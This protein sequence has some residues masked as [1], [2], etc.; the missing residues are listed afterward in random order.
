MRRPSSSGGSSVNS[1]RPATP[2]VRT[3]HTAPKLPRS[4]TPTSRSTLP[5]PKSVVGQPRSSTPVQSSTP[6]SRSS[7]PPASKL[8]S[9]S[10]TPTRRPS[11]PSGLQATVAPPSH[12]SY[13]TKSGSATSSNT[14]SIPAVSSVTRSGPRTNSIA[15]SGPTNSIQRSIPP[16]NSVL[17]SCPTVSKIAAPSRGTSPAIRSRPWKP[18]EMPGYSHDTP[19]NL[20]TTLPER[21]SPARGRPGAPS[22]TRSSSI[23]NVPSARPRRQSCSPSRGT[24]PK[25]NVVSGSSVPAS[26]RSGVNRG[27]SDSPVVIGTKM[28]ERV[29]NSRR[30]APPKHDNL[31]SSN[32]CSVKSSLSPD[33]IGFGRTLSKKSLDM[34]MRHMDIRRSIP[35]TLRPLM[36]NI[37]ASSFYSVKSGFMRGR[38]VSA[39]GSSLATSSNASSEQSVSNSAFCLEGNEIEHDQYSEKGGR[40]L[41]SFSTAR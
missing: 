11:T 5:P 19:P 16:A 24:A 34:A 8:A 18:S 39:S 41:P 35:N 2:T 3:T 37:P 32:P 9:R 13:V 33:S 30:L 22:S 17:K 21:S 29:V 23:D 14:K 7:V 38:A 36:N 1:S 28:V 4:S 40:M 26:N 31:H 6:M 10:S 12:S 15:G 20:K 27:S 25:G